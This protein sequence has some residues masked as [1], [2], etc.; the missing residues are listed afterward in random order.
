MVKHLSKFIICVILI[1]SCGGNENING[2]DPPVTP[3]NNPSINSLLPNTGSVG[4]EIQIIGKNFNETG[5][6]ITVMFGNAESIIKAVS[7]DK[8][9]VIVP[10]NDGV[11]SVSVKVKD[12]I[13][14]SSK[15]IYKEVG[16]KIRIL[17][18]GMYAPYEVE[19]VKTFR[20]VSHIRLANGD[21][22]TIHGSQASISSD[23][24]KTW[25]SIDMV[26]TGKYGISS[27]ECVQTK[28]GVII[29]AFM[30]TKERKWTWNNGLFDAPGATLPTYVVR[31]V[32]GGATWL[33][34]QK[35]HDDWT[36]AIRSIIETKSGIVIFTS[37]KLL[38]NP[39]R[40][41]VLTYTSKDN[42]TTWTTSNILDNPTSRG[43]HSGLMES[44]VVQLNDGRI[45]QLI[46]TNWD[47]IYES[48]SNDDGLTWD[49]PQKTD[50]DASSS[51]HSILRL[52]SGRL[53][54]AWNRVFPEGKTY[55]PRFGGVQAP[56]LSE[57]AAS[58][59]RHEYS[60]A[61][62]SDEGKTWSTPR[63]IA[64]YKD[65]IQPEGNSDSSKW[66]SYGH[67]FE[68]EPGVIMI[69]TEAGGLR[70]KI[71]EKDFI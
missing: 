47:Y 55:T 48:F 70:I 68:L 17:S 63:I 57:V 11:V 40:H 16:E 9:T 49:T 19:E 32:D 14:N 46:R 64:R 42:G 31:S 61:F 10:E 52:Q 53:M 8:L 33:E 35:M 28:D 37:M 50:I 71:N 69:T 18:T 29:V 21:I 15:F 4:D 43:D 51:P 27:A 23:E 62:S 30:N 26:D 36:G 45:W 7:K 67:L 56:Q 24:G 1:S 6:D 54:L 2:E 3:G 60:I 20:G 59:M 12:K 34:P 66:I 38:H 22:F 65:Y 5:Q 25:R 13:S 58:W 39:G 41:A 44:T